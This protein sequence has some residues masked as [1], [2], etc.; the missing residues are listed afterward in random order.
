MAYKPMYSLSSPLDWS[1]LTHILAST[2]MS[3]NYKAKKSPFYTVPL[4]E[5]YHSVFQDGQ[6]FGQ[7]TAGTSHSQNP[8]IYTS[9]ES[10]QAEK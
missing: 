2:K 9:K 1:Q 3:V 7:K 6:I 10:S 5:N 8:N 4:P